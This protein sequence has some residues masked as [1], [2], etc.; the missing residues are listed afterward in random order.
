M[1]KPYNQNQ[2]N[3]KKQRVKLSDNIEI[4]LPDFNIFPEDFHDL[5]EFYKKE[6]EEVIPIHNS[7]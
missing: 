2:K 5:D 1:Q 3:D 7:K 6:E 4:N